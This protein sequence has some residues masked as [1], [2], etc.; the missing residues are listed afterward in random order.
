MPAAAAMAAAAAGPLPLL[1]P[2]ARPTPV[3]LVGRPGAGKTSL[4]RALAGLPDAAGA[5][6]A[7]SGGAV[8]YE[9]AAGG[10]CPRSISFWDLHADHRDELRELEGLLLAGPAAGGA[11]PLVVFVFA[12]DSLPSFSFVEERL[13]EL[14][15]AGARGLLVG[16]K[17]GNVA[18]RKVAAR[19]VAAFAA[20]RALPFFQVP[21]RAA[22]GAVAPELLM[23]LGELAAEA[24]G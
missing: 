1:P 17:G 13:G 14:G 20:A 6:A 7:S 3:L 12:F 23:V 10:P 5:P 21:D 4:V 22:Y 16:T 18:E 24:A 2:A 8:C 9:R 19:D 11:P 15:A